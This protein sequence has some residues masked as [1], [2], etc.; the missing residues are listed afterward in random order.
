[1]V[2]LDWQRL[3]ALVIESDDWGLAAWAPDEQA[4]RVLA[5]MPAFRTEAGRRYGG[6]TLESVDDVR[7]LVA[8]LMEFRGGDGFPPAW[9]ANTVVAAPQ[10]DRLRPP[11]FE[12]GDLPLAEPSEA[13]PRWARPG[14]CKAVDEACD[15]GLW[16]PELH[17]LHHLPET[18]W[19][20]ALRRGAADARRAHEQHSPICEAVESSGEYDPSEPRDLRTRNL[21]RAVER[22]TARFGRPP[23]SFCAPD[24]RWDA[25]VED[26]ARGLG[27]TTFQ[28]GGEQIGHRFP[29]LRRLALR[30]Q[31]PNRN[32]DIFYL[33]PRVAFEPSAVTPDALPALCATVRRAV[34]NA[35]QRGQPA[36]LS[37]HRLNYAHLKPEHAAAG[38]AALRS[39]LQVLVEDG[40]VFLVDAEVRQ[41]EDHAWSVRRFGAKAALVRYY[42]VPR[43][44]VRFPAPE[45][46][47][48]ARLREGG[49][50]GESD[51]RVE[52]QHVVAR[53]NVGEYLIE[54]D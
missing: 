28:G 48:A 9:Q 27:V 35:W 39:L 43:E 16:W 32:G 11:M 46:V 2:N 49:G 51:V 21:Q 26:D 4:H 19:L 34:R 3:K 20:T 24:Y 15:S 25:T 14:L 44:P 22:F 31:W 18:A 17:G 47:R 41:L 38:R 53:L 23:G 12:V 40:A 7:Q 52:D 29:R 36:V 50:R 1:M 5:D 13:S 45:G 30:Y 6:S 8:T 42:G 54:W 10:F 33:P 37:T